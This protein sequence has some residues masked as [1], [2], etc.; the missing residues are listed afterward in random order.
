MELNYQI[1]E[2][3][4]IKRILILA[5]S[6]KINA[7]LNEVITSENRRNMWIAINGEHMPNDIAKKVG[8]S[9]MAVSKFMKTVI[10][11]HLVD[12]V[13]GNPPKKIIEHVPADWLKE[14]N[15]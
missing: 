3:R 14:R 11:A 6:D 4:A 9:T 12:Y 8:V 1:N 7:Y 2:L 15:E 10:D 5:H 13:K